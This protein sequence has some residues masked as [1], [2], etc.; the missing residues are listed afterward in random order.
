MVIKKKKALISVFD[1]TN[2]EWL[3]K[4]LTELGFGIIATSGTAN[5]LKQ[6]GIQVT[7]V[8]EITGFS[9]TLDGRIKTLHPYLYAGIL[10]S[11]NRPD[12]EAV[13]KQRN[14]EYIDLVIVNLYPFEQKMND[15]S[16]SLEELVNEIDIGGVSLLRAAAK[17]YFY[18]TPV[19]NPN[20]YTQLIKELKENNGE[21]PISTKLAFAYE[22]FSYT[23]QYDAIIAYFFY[24]QTLSESVFAPDVLVLPFSKISD[25]R[26]G[27]NPHQ[28]A[29]FYRLLFSTEKIGLANAEKLQGKELSFNNLCDLDVAWNLVNEFE[30]PA[31][32][33]IKHTNPCGVAIGENSKD[34]YTRAFE[35]DPVSAYGGIVGFNFSVDKDCALKIA[36]NFIDAVIAPHYSEE[37]LSILKNKKNLRILVLPNVQKKSMHN[38]WSIKEISGGILIQEPDKL[39]LKEAQ[40]SVVTDTEPTPEQFQDLIFAYTVVK[41]AKSNAI[42]IAKNKRTLGIGAG[43]TNRIDALRLAAYRANGKTQS[44]VLASDGFFPFRDCIDEASKLGISAIIQ[45]GGS[46]RDKE[47]ITVANQHKIAMVFTG[48]R[49][50]SH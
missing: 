14:I 42:V 28:K 40:L 6:S 32:A 24:K 41:Y 31:A 34:A 36:E 29:A 13:L 20:R 46:I 27:E 33:I 26:Y 48:I 50:F 17:N 22:A 47:V 10:A 23:A 19:V 45:P 2:I 5:Q 44:A 43:Q 15:P 8:S 4:N 7:E 25:L 21:L 37:A 1:K 39:I 18:V 9:E 16:I 12:H 38:L 30:E 35:A 49:H 3:A 11:R